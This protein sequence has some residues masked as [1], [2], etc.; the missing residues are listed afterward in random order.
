MLTL[1]GFNICVFSK[2]AEIFKHYPKFGHCCRRVCVC[3][4]VLTGVDQC[5]FP[6]FSNQSTCHQI[7]TMRAPSHIHTH[8][9][10]LWL[11]PLHHHHHHHHL[12]SVCLTQWSL[13]TGSVY[14][15]LRHL[16]HD[17]FICS[18]FSASSDRTAGFRGTLLSHIL[19]SLLLL[20]PHSLF[21]SL[22][23]I[24]LP[25]ADWVYK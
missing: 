3:V 5:E 17:H 6:A 19:S 21:F 7:D 25:A 13:W 15:H 18:H 4:C 2:G 1:L 20:P 22:C 11:V 14:Q 10:K 24:V 8:L 9:L 23:P 12:L 16:F